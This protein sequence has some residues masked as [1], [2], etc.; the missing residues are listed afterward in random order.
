MAQDE[1]TLFSKRR[2]FNGRGFTLIELLVVIAIIGILIALLMPAVQR[3]REAARRTQCI[4]NLHQIVL[5]AH[6][7]ESS[8]K[9]FPPGW[10]QDEYVCDYR[11]HNS[12]TAGHPV[13]VRIVNRQINGQP[14]NNPPQPNTNNQLYNIVTLTQWDL[15]SYWS[16][17]AMLLPELGQTTVNLNFNYTKYDPNNWAGIQI[18]IDTYVCP[19]TDLPSGRWHNLGYTT[20]RGVMGYWQST[21][22]NDPFYVDPNADPYSPLNNGMFFQNSALSFRDVTDGESNT[23][24]FGDTLFGGFWGDNYSCCARLREDR[25]NFDDYWQDPPADTSTCPTGNELNEPLVG[26]QFFGF[27]SL[28]GDV[29]NFALVDGSTRSISKQIDTNL[30]RALFTRNGQDRIT[31]DF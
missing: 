16:W 14:Q 3:A 2:P 4:N 21:Y 11:L 15:G 20:Y 26:P 27:G 30:L 8:H 10:T 6:N 1:S 19:S 12:E 18:P 22:P 17:H 5:A 24:M 31:D 28:H 23:L 9:V 13:T 25:E 29:C 7:Y